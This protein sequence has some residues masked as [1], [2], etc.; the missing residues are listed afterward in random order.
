MKLETPDTKSFRNFLLQEFESA[1]P[2]AWFSQETAAAVRDCSIATIERDRWAGK[3]IPFIKS[4]RSV[5]YR[6]KEILN[7]LEEHRSFQSTTQYATGEVT[8]K[9]CKSTEV[10]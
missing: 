6:K 3:G 8:P 1:P 9:F 7:W 5:R 2:E 10:V 4:G